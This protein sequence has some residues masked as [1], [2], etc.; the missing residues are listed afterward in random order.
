MKTKQNPQSGNMLVYILGAVFLLGILFVVMRSGYQPGAGID[1]ERAMLYAS[2]IQKY[3]GELETGVNMIMSNGKS[4]TD[5]RF[6]HSKWAGYGTA[7]DT[8]SRQVFESTGGGVE[9]KAPPAGSQTTTTAWVI[10]GSNT[11]DGV[12]STCITAS[13]SD[14]VAILPNVQKEVCVTLN[15]NSGV[16]NPDGNP[17]QETGNVSLTPLFQGT[18]SYAQGIEVTGGHSFAKKEGCFEG[19]GT[20]A[21]S[22]YHYYRVLMSR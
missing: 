9:W 15:N 1:G 21:A 11:V 8:P 22:T 12:G 17:P 10:T 7:G 19:G 6:A 20:P 13:C 18:F 3:A 5:L 4:E 16:N 2:Q 14:L